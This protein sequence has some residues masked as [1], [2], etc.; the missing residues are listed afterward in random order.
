MSTYG[1]VITTSKLNELLEHVF[2]TNNQLQSKGM[3]STPILIWGKHGLGKTQSVLDYAKEKGWKIAYCA[4]AQF[5]EMGDLHGMPTILDPNPSLHGDEITVYSPPSWIPKE[6]GPG[7][8]VLDDINRAD[9]RMLRGVMQLLQNFELLSWKLPPKW[10]IVATANPDDGNYS[11]TTMDDAMLT[12]MLHVTVEFDV[13]SWLQ[14][15][16]KSG[17]D[18][19]GIDFVSTYP[20][21]ITGQRTTPR[22]L[23]QFFD[24]IK[25]IPDL[26]SNLDLVEILAHSALD[27]VTVATF[28]GFINDDLTVLISPEAILNSE[29]WKFT[30]GQ[31]VNIV[32]GKNGEQRLDRI[33]TM[34]MRLYFYL[35]SNQ[36]NSSPSH[37]ENLV[38]F[39]LLDSIPNDLKM[40]F[41]L[42]ISKEGS[43]EVKEL[44]KDP[45]LA[46][47][48]LGSM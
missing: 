26:K 13:K 32:N 8:L 5:E 9:D 40:S 43:A 12:R 29:D 34:V 42:D 48:L 44:L 21:S 3:R 20:E 14:W 30:E 18:S 17:I 47:L 6:D 36:Y 41:Y 16:V 37:K 15:A 35:T 31:I 38:K 1:K 27:D 46:K 33:S 7:L 25:S 2:E 39:L 11:V 19:R 4:P 24:Q 45:R 10:Q 28:I 23:V 22:S